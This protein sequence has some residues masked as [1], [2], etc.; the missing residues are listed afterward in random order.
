M[1]R[2]NIDLFAVTV[3]VLLAAAWSFA[4]HSGIVSAIASEQMQTPQRLT[5][6]VIHVPQPFVFHCY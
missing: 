2:R 3:I 6:V 4:G 5:H 1:M